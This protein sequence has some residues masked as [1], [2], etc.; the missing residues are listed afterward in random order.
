LPEIPFTYTDFF[1]KERS[2]NTDFAN[3]LLKARI[4]GA[5]SAASAQPSRVATEVPPELTAAPLTL[6][7]VDDATLSKLLD[8]PTKSYSDEEAGLVSKFY[9][10]NQ[11]PLPPSLLARLQKK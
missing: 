6:E 2:K 11:I 5:K 4:D 3:M 9:Q 7:T 10:A 1:Q 8:K